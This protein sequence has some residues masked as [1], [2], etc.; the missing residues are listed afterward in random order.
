[1]FNA[2]K[3][4][5]TADSAPNP[6]QLFLFPMQFAKIS[7]QNPRNHITASCHLIAN[8]FPNF[9]VKQTL[10]SKLARL[11][12]R[13]TNNKHFSGVFCDLSSEGDL[14]DIYVG[15][16]EHIIKEEDFSLL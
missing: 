8:N 13:T 14:L 5:A 12:A 10:L 15:T 2:D 7:L 1:M 9:A 3:A 16:D 4:P 6:W 11:N